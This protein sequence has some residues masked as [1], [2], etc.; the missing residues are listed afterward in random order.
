MREMSGGV[1]ERPGKNGVN[2]TMRSFLC[3][4]SLQSNTFYV[5]FPK[6]FQISQASSMRVYFFLTGTV[7]CPW[8]LDSFPPMN[9]TANCSEI[10]TKSDETSIEFV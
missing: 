10:Q 1:G 8:M 2:V 9:L 4:A 6:V 5:I 3:L 7:A